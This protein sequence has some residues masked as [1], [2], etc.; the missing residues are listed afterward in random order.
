RAEAVGPAGRRRR[1]G[2]AEDDQV[3][4]LLLQRQV[5]L[6]LDAPA[7]AGEVLGQRHAEDAMPGDGHARLRCCRRPGRPATLPTRT[8]YET[9]AAQGSAAV[10]ERLPTPG[11]PARPSVYSVR[12]PFRTGIRTFLF[13]RGCEGSAPRLSCPFSRWLWIP[14]GR[15]LGSL[16][17]PARSIG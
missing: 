6:D 17:R 11:G 16:R 9:T 5:D 14:V 3:E 8:F 4:A 13:S 2:A 1:A 12:V 7:G 15:R 10:P